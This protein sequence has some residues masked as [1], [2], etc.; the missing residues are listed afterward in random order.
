MGKSSK[1]KAQFNSFKKELKFEIGEQFELNEF[2]IKT[3]KSVS[4]NNI[5][6]DVY[7]YIKDDIREVFNLKITKILLFYN[8]D[9]LSAIHYYFD[10]NGLNI[11]MKQMDKLLKNST[12]EVVKGVKKATYE[13][14]DGNHLTIELDNSPKLIY[15]KI[16]ETF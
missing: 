7:Q 5:E 1:E 14:S 11:L 6:Y 8:A 12:E 4:I 16:K 9:I 15:S 2:N 13:I 3:L 10:G